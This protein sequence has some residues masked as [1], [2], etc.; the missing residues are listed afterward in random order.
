MGLTVLSV[1]PAQA[2]PITANYGHW[3]QDCPYGITVRLGG[4]GGWRYFMR[5]AIDGWNWYVA[6]N[7]WAAP[8][9]TR[10]VEVPWDGKL[11]YARCTVD[12][13]EVWDAPGAGRAGVA[14][15]HD[16]HHFAGAVVE[17]QGRTWFNTNNFQK[18]L[19]AAHELQHA[20]G[21][22]HNPYCSS[23]MHQSCWA[24]L[25]HNWRDV[26][27]LNRLYTHKHP[28]TYPTSSG[29]GGGLLGWLLTDGPETATTDEDPA[30]PDTT[31]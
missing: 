15:F 20:M 19:I 27:T 17:L 28:T 13:D 12:M 1:V 16:N 4:G 25:G 31:Q 7:Y 26:D 10:I 6:P 21:L 14:Q 30:M 23:L 3:G 2:D 5:R 22:G 11:T 8:K 18:D 9:I 29:G 24:T